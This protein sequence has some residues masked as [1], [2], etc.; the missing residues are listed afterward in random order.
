MTDPMKSRREEF[1]SGNLRDR[2]NETLLSLG[3]LLGV[4]SCTRREKIAALRDIANDAKVKADVLQRWL[5]DEER[6]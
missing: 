4:R 2:K 3:R 5:N 6:A 1:F